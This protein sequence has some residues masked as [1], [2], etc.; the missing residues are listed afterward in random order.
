MSVTPK[1]QKIIYIILFLLT[2]IGVAIVV[3]RATGIVPVIVHGIR[4]SAEPSNPQLKVLKRLDAI[5]ERHAWLTL[6]HIIPGLIF[7]LSGLLYFTARFPRTAHWHELTY[8][9]FWISGIFTGITAFIMSVT[10]PAIG[11]FNQ[12]A[13]TILFSSLF[14]YFLTKSVLAKMSD[15]SFELRLWSIR[16]YGIGLAI[17]TIRPIIGIFFA[18]SRL[19]GLSPEEFFGTAFWIGFSLHLI[20]TEAWIQ[21]HWKFTLP[22]P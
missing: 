3:R 9:F 4:P 16:S 17:A 8:R 19:T 18:T 12:A 11:G 15:R 10:M 1:P 14:L 2:L 13:S 22:E 7:L 5:F 21:R 20:V 6:V